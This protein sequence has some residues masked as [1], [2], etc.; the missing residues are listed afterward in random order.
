L[1][2][3]QRG[4][5]QYALRLFPIGGFVAMEGENEDSS[6]TR[7][8]CN[9]K[10]WKRFVITT[11][12]AIMNIA[13]GLVLVFYLTTQM[14]L[15]GTTQISKFA[16]NAVTS[17]W[18]QAEDTILR[19]NGHKVKTSND[20]TYEFLRDR[21]G[22]MEMECARG[23]QRL[24]LP[25]VQFA[26]QDIDGVRIIHLDFSIYGAPPTPM[27]TVRYTLNWTASIVKQVWGSLVD[28]LTGR[29]GF[30]Q[31]SGPVGITK[32]IGEVAAARNWDSLIMMMAFITINLGVFN[33]LPVPALDG[34]R[35]LFLLIELVRR[36][37][38]D[39]KYEGY[40]H[41]AGFMLLIG[42][43]IAVTFKDIL[44]IFIS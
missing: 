6:D 20:L 35:L 18:L 30:S 29:F 26:M 21:D 33:L 13:L 27:G 19:V 3:F 23:G 31:M 41:A 22:M 25:E 40:V 14:N 9:A 8:F 42:L 5:T 43:M 7:A 34:G 10:L 44:K 15:F 4:E 17:Q 39:P 28:L 36:K 1:L 24:T 32:Q 2:R 11:A 38:V 12:G 16:E 37:P